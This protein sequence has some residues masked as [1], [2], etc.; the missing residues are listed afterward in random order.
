[1]MLLLVACVVA[2]SAGSGR[3]LC[4]K[5]REEWAQV[6]AAMQAGQMIDSYDATPEQNANARRRF[7]ILKDTVAQCNSPDGRYRK[8][9]NGRRTII[10][11]RN[12]RRQYAVRRKNGQFLDIQ[13]IGESSRRDQ[14]RKHLETADRME[15]PRRVPTPP[16]EATDDEY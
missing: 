16:V 4:E 12:G 6:G 1:M 10:H 2:V 5:A 9:Y 3:T 11:R 7:R 15:L 8:P 13:D 14:R